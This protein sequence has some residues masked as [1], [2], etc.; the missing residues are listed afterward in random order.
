MWNFCIRLVFEAALELTYSCILNLNYGGWHDRPWG[1]KLNF[2]FACAF[3]LILLL[4]PIAL[5]LFYCLNFDRIQTD[6]TFNETYGAP[7]DGLL[8]NR[9]IVLAYPVVFVSKR[10]LFAAIAFYINKYATMQIFL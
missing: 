8:V 3:A 2:A 6:E 4:S 1:A 9:R 10:M 7:Y 5:S